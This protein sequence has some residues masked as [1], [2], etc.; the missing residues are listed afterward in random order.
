MRVAARQPRTW[1]GDAVGR[2]QECLNALRSFFAM[3]KI[4]GTP[5]MRRHIPARRATTNYFSNSFIFKTEIEKE[6]LPRDRTPALGAGGP[7]LES[8]RPDH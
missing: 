3:G 7:R 2:G 8:G 6:G 1:T 4:R 5:C